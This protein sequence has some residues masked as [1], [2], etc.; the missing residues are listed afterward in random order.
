M[1]TA[2][3]KSEQISRV[4]LH[5]SEVSSEMQEF[6]EEVQRILGYS[7][8]KQ[9]LKGNVLRNLLASIEVDILDEKQVKSYKKY[10]EE[11]FDPGLEV[12]A[13]EEEE[14]DDEFF[15]WDSV[16]IKEYDE[17]IPEFVLAKAIEL[18][19]RLPE[20]KLYIEY[21]GEKDPFLIATY[22]E[23]KYYIEV[24]DEPKFEGRLTKEPVKE[25][26]AKA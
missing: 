6:A 19:K 1:A 11:N 7:R 14:S 21:F 3:T 16:S 22:G 20:V 2:I 8:L 12:E 15:G 26:K 4:T 18:K 5:K 13:E 25:K 23:E 17:P 9:N 10:V 24:W